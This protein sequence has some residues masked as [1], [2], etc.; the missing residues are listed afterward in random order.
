MKIKLFTNPLQLHKKL[1]FGKKRV[2]WKRRILR[3][4]AFGFGSLVLI[5]I[6][7]FAWYSK[8]LP[9][10]GK[11]KAHKQS[12][13]TQLFDRN[14][15]AL[16]AVSG[17]ER[18]I[19]I[20]K[21]AFKDPAYNNIKNATI[22]IEDKNFYKHKGFYPKSIIRAVFSNVQSGDSSQGGSTITQQYV[23][24]ALLSP[25]KSITRKIKELIL[26]IE[27]E[28]M[29][30]KDEILGLYLNEIPYGGNV[31][32]IEAA[33]N[34]YF[35]KSAKDLSLSEAATLAAL[36]Q[37]PSYLSPYGPRLEKL[38]SR[39]D[40]VLDQMQKQSYIS[41]AE[42]KTAQETAPLKRK[43]FTD[44]KE[45]IIAPHFVFYAKEKL[46]EILG[47]DDLAERMVEEGG[48]RVTT[49][50]DLDYQALA[51][52]AVEKGKNLASVGA[53]NASLVATDPQKGEVLAMVGS[54]NYFDTENDGNFN[55]AI[56]ERQPGSSIKP[57][58][59]SAAFKKPEFSPS[60]V[61]Y[62]LK[63][64]FNGYIPQNADGG[65]RGSL[66]IR[67]A[68]GSS[69]NIPAVKTLALIGIDEALKTAHDM[70]ITTL[71]DRNRYGLS[72][73]LGGGEVKL[74]DMVTAYGVLANNG[75]LRPT[76]AI[77]KIE[78]PSGKILYDSEKDRKDKE[79][80]DPQIAYEMTSILTD[81]N[82]KKPVFGRVMSYFTFGDYPVAAKTGTTNESRDA[83]TLGYTPNFVAG[84]WVGNNDNTPM[85]AGG[86]I[87]AAPIWH[88]FMNKIINIRPKDSFIKP[89]GIQEVNVEYY[90]NKLP[91]Q[92]S[93][94]FTKDIF[95]SWQVPTE[96]DSTNVVKKVCKEN[97]LLATSSTPASLVEDRVYRFIHS[98][99][100]DNPNWEGPVLAWAQ[101]NGLN[102]S[103]PTQKCD[104]T[105][106]KP[107]ISITSPTSGSTVSGNFTISVEGSTQSSVKSVEV[108]IDGVSIAQGASLPYQTK[109][110][111]SNLSS[112]SHTVSAKVIDTNDT[113]SE[114]SIIF[115]V[116]KDSEAPGVAS[117]VSLSWSINEGIN[118]S[119]R[120]PSD[121]DFAS[122][123]IY[124]STSSGQLGT[125]FTSKSNSPGTVDSTLIPKQKLS[126]INTY[127]ITLRAVDSFGNEN[128]NLNQYPVQVSYNTNTT[129]SFTPSP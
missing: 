112:G 40:L 53:N 69:L 46:I 48:L 55:T 52:E 5:M 30:S 43:D 128:T 72:L 118:I 37:S 85:K 127:F 67:Q 56:A 129:P 86:A 49:S 103:P 38:I 123:N 96:K 19:L 99:K 71:N 84:V 13:S 34:R 75:K 61:L 17:E 109:Y 78:D 100:P 62:D 68:I 60:R 54:L 27:I 4:L 8:D 18:R 58:I 90:S 64:D 121:S 83:W 1:L 6:L 23:K 89:D 101:A 120:N 97:G 110:N 80:L 124:Y 70:G 57:I 113:S 73:T 119:W 45:S 87:A 31:Y 122:M 12:A 76:T 44:P 116:N 16:Y 29:F 74:V 102:A 93:E 20:D 10:P 105:T 51:E 50:L 95:A 65:F 125:K 35:N 2:N 104:I 7:M 21:E 24:N 15:K 91:T 98:E 94:K 36:P 111:A 59:Y 47:N 66:T 92:Y 79:A 107:D 126:A 9:T 26:S 63:T 81:L 33:A 88:Y 14:G 28:F 22:A 77:L 11:I 3:F 106:V 25:Q 39:K 115:A 82:A 117:N 41:E 108:Y 42:M 32:G 114:T